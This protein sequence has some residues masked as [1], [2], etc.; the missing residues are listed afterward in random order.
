MY[1]FV[2]LYLQ[3]RD[4]TSN[5]ATAYSSSKALS[6]THTITQKRGTLTFTTQYRCS[7]TAFQSIHHACTATSQLDSLNADYEMKRYRFVDCV[8]YSTGSAA[9]RQR[10][11]GWG[12]YQ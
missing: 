8:Q 4:G 10:I 6:K 7:S 3:G 5:N 2:N 9:M 1:I 11:Y 12:H